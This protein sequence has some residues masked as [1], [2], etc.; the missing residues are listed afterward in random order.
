M[1]EE[2]Q[3]KLVQT[4]QE[5]KTIIST[6]GVGGL[7]IL[8]GTLAKYK[9]E[10]VVSGWNFN[11]SVPSLFLTE[12]GVA[13]IVG[14]IVAGLIERRAR[15]RADETHEQRRREIE[16]DVFRHLFGFGLDKSVA[17]E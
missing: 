17:R 13:F 16:Q 15:S 10:V 4:Y 5:F 14:A 1:K 3:A 9:T 8:A 6:A 2:T 12:M 7:F 11:L